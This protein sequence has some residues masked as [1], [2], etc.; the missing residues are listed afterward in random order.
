MPSKSVKSSAESRERHKSHGVRNKFLAIAGVILL[1]EVVLSLAGKAESPSRVDNSQKWIDYV[2]SNCPVMGEISNDDHT[3]WNYV[4]LECGASKI[5]DTRIY[6]THRNDIPDHGSVNIRGVVDANGNLIGCEAQGIT[7]NDNP[8]NGK[9]PRRMKEAL[10]LKEAGA[11]PACDLLVDDQKWL[12]KPES[13]MTVLVDGTAAILMFNVE[14]DSLSILGDRNSELRRS[15]ELV[16]NSPADLLNKSATYQFIDAMSKEG[17]IL[18][19][20][21]S[22]PEGVE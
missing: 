3:V 19:G 10:A 17:L 9:M 11:V 22:I 14:P 20:G 2:A 16:P 8:D 21:V 5:I 12:G 18:G 15:W 7:I 4:P 1:T 6:E 13:E